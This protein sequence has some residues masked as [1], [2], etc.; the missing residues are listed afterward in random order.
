M[1]KFPKSQKRYPGILEEFL[2]NSWGMH[3]L[4]GGTD[5]NQLQAAVEE[6]ALAKAMVVAGDGDS[7][8]NVNNDDSGRGCGI[9]MTTKTMA[10]VVVGGTD[11][12]CLKATA[13]GQR[14]QRRW[15]QKQQRKWGQRL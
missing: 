5:N 2:C 12:N 4:A 8:D 15:Q 10:M 1:P 6:V 9:A 14:W 7:G 11:N 13:E 3:N